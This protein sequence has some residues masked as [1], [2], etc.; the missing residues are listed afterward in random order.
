MKMQVQLQIHTRETQGILQYI[1]IWLFI[2]LS[3]R[4]RHTMSLVPYKTAFPGLVTSFVSLRS[5]NIHYNSK[6]ES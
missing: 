4:K 5:Q 3:H 6:Q 2:F 1:I